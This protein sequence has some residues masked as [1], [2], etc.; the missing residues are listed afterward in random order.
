MRTGLLDGQE[1]GKDLADLFGELGMPVDVLGHGRT[2]APPVSFEE[3]LGQDLHGIA[4]E[5]RVGH[6]VPRPGA[7]G[8]V[9]EHA[10]AARGGSA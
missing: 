5:V 1:G 10:G 7:A 2:L 9:A 3:F 8:K 6:R 4:P